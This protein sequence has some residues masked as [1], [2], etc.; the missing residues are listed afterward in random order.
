MPRVAGR[1][2]ARAGRDGRAGGRSW[3]WERVYG[4]FP[5]KIGLNKDIENKRFLFDSCVAVDAMQQMKRDYAEGV[6]DP[7]QPGTNSHRLDAYLR[8]FKIAP[9]VE[10]P[11]SSLIRSWIRE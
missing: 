3:D 6:P 8:H 9:K 5:A 10:L 2:D 11:S 4:T 7:E 1:C